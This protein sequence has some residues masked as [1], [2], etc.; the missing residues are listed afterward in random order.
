MIDLLAESV[1]VKTDGLFLIVL[2]ASGS[3]KSHFLGTYPG[4]TL[5]LYGA[6]ESHGPAS[7]QKT[8]KDNL[9]AIPWDRSKDGDLPADQIL[10]RIKSMLDPAVLKAAGVK[11][12]VIDS[13]TNLCLDVKKMTAFRQRCSDAKGNHNAF[14]ETEAL[15]EILS[16]VIR[17]LHMLNEVHGIDAICTIDLQVQV[18][19]S[20]GEIVESKPGLPTF[21]VGKAVIQQFPDVL[22]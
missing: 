20:K 8:C 16:V 2:G 5:M 3:G 21:G 15:I 9:I 11:C 14:K 17:Q 7:A 19:G 22:V 10:P 1:K 13:I 6:G 18:V 12:V 4:K